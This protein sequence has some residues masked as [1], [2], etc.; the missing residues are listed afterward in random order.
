M[1]KIGLISK[2]LVGFLSAL[3]LFVPLTANAQTTISKS[4]LP[5]HKDAYSN[6]IFITTPNNRSLSGDFFTN[7]LT[8]IISPNGIIGKYI[9]NPDGRHHHWFID[10]SFLDDVN[11]LAKGAQLVDGKKISADLN[12]QNFLKQLPVVV[13]NDPLQALAYGNP[14]GYWMRRLNPHNQNYYIDMGNI[15]LA[16]Y[17]SREFTPATDFQ[18]NSYYTLPSFT[19]STFIQTQ[20]SIESISAYLGQDQLSYLVLHLSAPLYVGVKKSTRNIYTRDEMQSINQ[21]LGRVSLSPGKFTLTSSNEKVPVTISN[22][23]PHSIKLRIEIA[24]LNSRVLIPSQIFVTVPRL[25]EKVYEKIVTTGSQ[26][27]GIKKMLFYWALNLGLRYEQHG[28]NGWWY[29][30]P[31]QCQKMFKI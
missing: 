20:K 17:F 4:P 12:A 8:R 30:F 18:F 1:K 13:G 5:A 7:S 23:F 28:A 9:L 11:A 10:P 24:T 29:E 27:T 14:S 26:V 2:I 15:I 16:S 31:G 3:I 21:L 22:K 19:V 25:L 6:N